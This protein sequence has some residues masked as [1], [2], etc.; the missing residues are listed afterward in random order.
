V[1]G[2]D[3]PIGDMPSIP[4]PQRHDADLHEQAEVAAEDRERAVQ[5][6]SKFHRVQIGGHSDLAPCAGWR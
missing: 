3:V 1:T 4:Q 2:N 6:L 5:D